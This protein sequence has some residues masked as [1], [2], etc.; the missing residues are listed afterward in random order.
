MSIMHRM[1][2]VPALAAILWAS[3]AA[4]AQILTPQPPPLA[5]WDS[6]VVQD[7]AA[8]I[9]AAAEQA[10][11]RASE[12]TGPGHSLQSTALVNLTSLAGAA[13]RF[14]G[15]LRQSPQNAALTRPDYL[16]L[17]AAWHQ[18]QQ[19]ILAAEYDASVMREFNR[20]GT[21]LD[22]LS[23]VYTQEWNREAAKAAAEVLRDALAGA[24]HTARQKALA[25]KPAD[26]RALSLLQRLAEE[27]GYFSRQL[28]LEPDPVGT[29]TDLRPLVNDY[30]LAM[31][32]LP[33]AGFGGYVEADMNRAGEALIKL[34]RTYEV[35]WNGSN[36]RA[37]V[38]AFRAATLHVTEAVAKRARE[39]D[40]YEA[41]AMDNL[42][43]LGRA[44]DFFSRELEL[45]PDQPLQ[46]Y[47]AFLMLVAAYDH[48]GLSLVRAHLGDRALGDF[49]SL[50]RQL[51]QLGRMYWAALDQPP[52]RL[53]GTVI[54][55]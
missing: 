30:A 16:S 18:A 37:I 26:S 25:D 8:Q 10:R 31:R 54:G 36:A 7:V 12:Q 49:N 3:A 45:R 42:G 44:A 23:V 52:T 11:L 34:R 55:R 41:R 9:R 13:Q 53:T 38:D 5:D 28:D 14:A 19:S 24:A 21:L 20:I 1:P 4:P 17:T 2:L 27:A 6:Q 29:G 39:D 33:A 15:R 50:E 35:P 32:N 40:V 47:P 22:R 43:V 51:T 46:T 48:V